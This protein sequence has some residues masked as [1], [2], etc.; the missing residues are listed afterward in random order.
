MLLKA[1]CKRG[2]TSRPERGPERVRESKSPRPRHR[3]VNALRRFSGSEFRGP[4]AETSR[5][6]HRVAL[7]LRVFSATLRSEI[8]TVKEVMNTAVATCAPESSLNSVIR[9]MR[10]HDCGFVP[11]VDS[12][13]VVVG[14][15]TDRDVCLAGTTKRPLA[16]VSVKE[17]MSHPVFSCFADENVKTVLVTMS[18]HRVRRLPVLNKSGHLEGVLSIDDIVRAP[19]RRGAPTAEDI[20]AALKAIYAR[21]AVEA[22]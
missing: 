22:V 6:R 13:G 7:Q 16:R 10:E 21:R 2:T 8:M 11:V 12:H 19:G 15:I 20:V 17:T 14:V 18:K 3:L 4:S 9:T 5:R 1:N